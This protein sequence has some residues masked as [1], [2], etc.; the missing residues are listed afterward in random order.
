MIS[1]SMRGSHLNRRSNELSECAEYG[2]QPD[3][4]MVV[5]ANSRERERRFSDME[6]YFAPDLDLNSFRRTNPRF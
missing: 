4:V 1:L 2:V 6:K 5:E 3:A